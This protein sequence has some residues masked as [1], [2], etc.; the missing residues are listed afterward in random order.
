M[1]HHPSVS[2]LLHQSGDDINQAA[3]VEVT[4]K[5]LFVR[6]REERERA[7]KITAKRSPVVRYLTETGNSAMLDCIK[8]V[9]DIVKFRIFNEIVQGMPPP[10]SNSRKTGRRSAI[11]NS[12]R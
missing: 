11:G 3:E 7:L 6:D 12:L 10:L 4:G 2:L 8:V 1:T 9:P 5:A